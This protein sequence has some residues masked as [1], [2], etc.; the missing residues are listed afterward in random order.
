MDE[1]TEEL[2]D[3]FRDVAGT[4]TVTAG[5]VTDRGTLSDPDEATV[6]TR[7]RTVIDRMAAHGDVATD[8]DM[9]H[10]IDLVRGFHRGMDDETLAERLGVDRTTVRTA[11]LDLHLFR[12]TDTD[13]PVAW[14]RLRRHLRETEDDAAIAETLGLDSD[15]VA[16]ARRVLAARDEAR[17]MSH[18]YRSAFRD[19]IPDANLADRLTESVGEDGLDE[20]AADI[21]TDVS[22]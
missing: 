8:L 21:E 9:D 11:R 13:A 17:R 20:A 4:D 2:R 15:T 18:R 14:E 16:T 7:L 5:Q 19:A 1:E 22:F 12:D 3:L 6:R 10:R